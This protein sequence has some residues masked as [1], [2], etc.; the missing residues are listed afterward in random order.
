MNFFTETMTSLVNKEQ[1]N[2]KYDHAGSHS[3]A[4]SLEVSYNLHNPGHCDFGDT[5]TCMALWLLKG[6]SGFNDSLNCTEGWYFMLPHASIDGSNG[7]AIKLHHGLIMSWNGT[8][9][10]HCTI[11]SKPNCDDKYSIFMGPKKYLLQR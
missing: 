6:S 7:V 2:L 11:Y 3:F 9:L 4:K 1:H 10:K 8:E 5:G